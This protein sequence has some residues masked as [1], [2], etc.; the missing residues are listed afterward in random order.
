MNI[1]PNTIVGIGTTTA[2]T[3]KFNSDEQ[4]F[5]ILQELLLHQLI[6]TKLFNH[7]GHGFETGWSYETVEPLQVYLLIILCNRDSFSKFRL[8][9]NEHESFPGTEKEVN[10]V[11]LQIPIIHSHW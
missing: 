9:W 7:S 3:L 1:V 8:T 2:L 4:N 11:E 6:L 5:I 10:I